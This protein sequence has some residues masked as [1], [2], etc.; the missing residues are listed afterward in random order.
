VAGQARGQPAAALRDLLWFNALDV[1]CA[2]GVALVVNVAIL[3]VSA[4]TFH[5][6]GG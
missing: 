3:L 2:L 6:A 4:A 1:A 5:Q